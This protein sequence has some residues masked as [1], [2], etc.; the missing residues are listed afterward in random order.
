M[1]IQDVLDFKANAPK[2]VYWVNSPGAMLD[3]CDMCK[4]SFGSVMY[5]ART[6]TGQWGN[7]CQACFRRYGSGLGTGKGQMYTKQADG[8]WLKTGG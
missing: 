4:G 5:D 6:R 7:L 8:R 3:V 1:K 2:P